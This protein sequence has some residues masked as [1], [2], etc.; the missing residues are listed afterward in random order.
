[1]VREA[2]VVGINNYLHLGEDMQLNAPA[3]DAELIARRLEAQGFWSVRRSPQ[4]RTKSDRD[5]VS[6][7]ENAWVTVQELEAA[8]E[9]L[10]YPQTERQKPDAALLYFSGHGLRKVGRRRTEGF[11][12]ASD[13]NPDE[14]RWGVSLKWLRELLQDSPIASQVVWLDC[15]H[16]G[17]LLNF[18]EGNPGEQGLARDRCFIAAS[19]DHQMAYEAMDVPYSELTRVLWQGFDQASGKSTNL[20]LVNFISENFQGRQRPVFHNSGNAIVLLPS[21]EQQHED[22]PIDSETRPYRGLVAFDN[23]ADDIRFFYGRTALIDQLLE[24]I[25]QQNFLAVLGPSGCGK[26]SVVRAGLLS[27]ISKGERQDTK[28]WH[29]LPIIKPVLKPDFTPLRGLAAAFIDP[30][31]PEKK[32]ERDLASYLHVLEEKKAIGLLELVADYDPNPVV[33]VIDQFEEVFT[34]CHKVEER[35]Q[36]FDCLFGA[37]EHDDHNLRQLR[38]VVTMR[39]DFLDKCLDRNYG[40]L[41]QQIDNGKVLVKPLTE[42]ELRQVIQEPAR[43]VGLEIPESLTKLMIRDVQKAPAGLPLLQYAL[44]EL[45]TVWKRQYDQN[46][47]QAGRTFSEA[48]YLDELG[49]V[50][51]ALRKRADT[52]FDDPESENYL[53]P[54]EQKVANWI[55]LELTQLGLSSEDTRR[56][57]VKQDLVTEQ[58]PEIIVDSVLSKLITA[59]LVVTA[60]EVFSS[61]SSDD[62]SEEVVVDVAHEALIRHWPRLRRLLEINRQELKLRRGILAEAIQ[63]LKADQ[64]PALLLWQDRQ[65]TEISRYL[66]KYGGMG[67]LNELTQVFIS[68]SKKEHRRRAVQDQKQQ[69][70]LDR[71]R[72]EAKLREEAMQILNLIAVRPF[73]DT[74]ARAIKAVGMS[75]DKLQGDVLTPLQTNLQSVIAKIKESRSF[76]GHSSSVRSVAFSPDGQTIVS[77]SSDNTIRLWRGNWQSWLVLC[78]DRLRYHPIF[79][80]PPDEV[81]REACEVCKRLVWNK[82]F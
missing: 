20:N 25:C 48:I 36:F 79:K 12:A 40:Q 15:C 22:K 26:S 49:G 31:A 23:K 78:C 56:R 29:L 50:E 4:G 61:G 67:R 6:R 59:R 34:L 13:V 53:T 8:I 24:M 69:Q 5:I 18:E 11:L 39:A 60:Y 28:N 70:D 68:Q 77:G 73:P 72:T 9:D 76:H 82:E 30:T 52:L 44:D 43:E 54:D 62:E 47:N 45:W 71:A 57:V 75:Y 55:F 7:R 80:D 42:P 38:V 32:Q 2:L 10:F 27:E 66:K 81:A 16:S 17:E 21:S 65:L 74:A 63:W 3:N 51:T 64:D 37:L 35:Q 19:Q 33:L 41:A 1:M 58:F 14:D 46:P